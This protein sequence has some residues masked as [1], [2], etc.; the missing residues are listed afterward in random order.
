MALPGIG[1]GTAE[2]LPARRRHRV[3]SGADAARG[4]TAT[5]AVT[6]RHDGARSARIRPHA[7]APCH[8]QRCGWTRFQCTDIDRN[9]VP[10]CAGIRYRL[11]PESSTDMGRITQS[12]E[13]R[14]SITL[15]PLRGASRNA[16]GRTGRPGDR[17]R[18]RQ[19]PPRSSATVKST[20]PAVPADAPGRK[21]PPARRRERHA[22]AESGAAA[23]AVPL[24][25]TGRGVCVAVRPA[26]LRH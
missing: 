10:T 2:S 1:T 14:M 16:P 26:A 20:A 21:R 18:H 6:G 11:A 12:I 8:R 5:V 3:H 19:P 25:C 24:H 7:S 13:P 9:A 15:K 23:R 17:R 22:A 4:Q